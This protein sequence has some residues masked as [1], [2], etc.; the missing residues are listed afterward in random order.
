MTGVRAPKSGDEI[1]GMTVDEIRSD[2][3]RLEQ[4]L[5][6]YYSNQKSLRQ[7]YLKHWVAIKD[8]KIVMADK[9]HDRLV[10]RLKERPCGR[11]GAKILYVEPEGTVYIY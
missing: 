4:D 2:L 8:M 6:W 1:G 10:Q 3:R 7:K 11:D 5:D 9:D